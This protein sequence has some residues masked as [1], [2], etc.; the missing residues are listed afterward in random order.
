[1]VA[2][3]W[4]NFNKFLF[5]NVT[6]LAE[7]WLAGSAWH[8]TTPVTQNSPMIWQRKW[9]SSPAQTVRSLSRRMVDA[10]TWLAQTVNTNGFG[11]VSERTETVSKF[12]LTTRTPLAVNV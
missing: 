7:Q 6:L 3:T 12:E 2:L 1:M 10:D 9:D 11:V 5:W 8:A 4:G